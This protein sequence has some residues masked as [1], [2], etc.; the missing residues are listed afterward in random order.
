MR[1]AIRSES[2]DITEWRNYLSKYRLFAASKALGQCLNRFRDLLRE[3]TKWSACRPN[4]LTSDAACFAFQ[5]LSR[6]AGCVARVLGSRQ[7]T[8]PHIL[9]SIVGNPALAGAVEADCPRR[10]D[11]FTQRHLQC[12][13]GR[14]A[15]PESLAILTSILRSAGIGV[16]P[17]ENDNQRLNQIKRKLSVTN[18][19]KI[20]EVSEDAVYVRR[21]DQEK[22]PWKLD[23]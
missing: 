1:Q 18:R 5:L 14:L 9:L 2:T 7:F 21:S 16:V 12:F 17:I 4:W 15:G 6:G 13:S 19:P 23:A 20:S 3:R 11:P 22:G 10:F 8:Y